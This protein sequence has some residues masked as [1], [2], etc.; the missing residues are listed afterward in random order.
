MWL[1]L[2]WAVKIM[3]IVGSNVQEAPTAKLKPSWSFAFFSPFRPHSYPLLIL[4]LCLKCADAPCQK[5]CPTN[6]D[7]K[8][9][10]TSIANKNYYG[11]AKM[12]LSDNPLG[13]TC[14]MVCPTSDLCVGGCNLYAS[15]EGPINIGGL[16]QFATEV[17]KAMNIPQIR[18]PSLP[19]LEDMPEAYQVKIALLGAGPASLSCAS[20][21]ARL[22]YSNITIFEKQEYLGGLS[23]SEIPQF[24]LPYDVV[25]FEAKLM[26]DLGVKIIFRKGLAVDGMTLHTLKEDGYKA[27][28]IGIGLPEPNRDSVFQGLKMNQGF[29]TSKDFLPLVAMASKP[30]MCGCHSPL[31]SIHGTVIVL[32][33]GDTAFDCATSALR[34]GARRVFVVFRKG[35]THIRA[36]PEEMELAK[37]EKCEFLPFLSPRKVVLKGGQ[38]VAM[39]FVRTEQDSDGNWKEDEDQIVRLKADVVISAFG[40]ILSDNKVREAMAPIKFNRWGLPEVDPETMQTSEPWVFAGGDVGGIANT[41]VESVNDGKQASWY[42]H[43]YIQSLY[44]VAVSAVPELPLFYTPVDLVDIS[45]E[46]AGLK[47]PNPFGLASAT[48]ATSSSMI[49]RAFEAGWGFAVTKT[50]SLDKDIVTNVSPR[51]V[52]GTTSGPLYGPG[53]GSF[54]NIELISEKTAAYWCKSIT[55]LKADFPNHVLIAS[56][57]CSYNRDDWTELSKMAEVAGADALELNLSCPH[58]MGER[59]MGLACGQDPELVRNI[60]RWVRQAVHIPFFAKLTPNVTDIVKIAMAAREGGA[61]GVTATNTVSGLM[62][63]KADSTPWPAVGRGLRTTYGG[64][65]GNAIRPI[66]LRAVSAIARALPGFPILATGGI[67]SAEAG[68]QFLHSGA[69]VLQVCSA[70]QNQDFTVIDDYCTGLRAL[71]YLKSIEELEDW[72][73]QSPATICHQKGKPVPRI[74]DLMGKCSVIAWST[75]LPDYA[76]HQYCSLKWPQFTSFG[77]LERTWNELLYNKEA[78]VMQNK[79][80][81]KESF[82]LMRLKMA[83]RISHSIAFP[84]FEKLPSFGPYLEQRKRIIAE[85]KIKLKAQNMA[86]ELPEK[87]HFVPKKP[88]PAIKDVIGKALQYIGT[89]GDLCNTEQVV[90]LIDEEMCINCGKCY[91]TCNDSG[92]QAIQFDPETH[93]PTVTDSCTGCTL[94]LSVCPIIDCIRM[95]SRT[96]PYEPRRGLPLAVNPAR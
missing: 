49:R 68:L 22:G 88:I 52:R 76:Y 65:S 70:I 8:S 41:T 87:K 20:F 82:G 72:N 93:L 35:F 63:L 29:Y 4:A 55:E 19:P 92:Y 38:I 27:V 75:W 21:L 44:G 5:S 61:D 50:F 9:F 51:I 85:N 34:C 53:Q 73:G 84:G 60:C 96:T 15:E 11:A 77:S 31:P 67:D 39:E 78:A 64:M 3:S 24:R 57:M 40:S 46:M 13:L 2:C 48:P 69:S 37:E 25:N 94:C 12:I 26:K 33:A 71:L 28:F 83:S 45:V 47:F 66:A 6:L 1:L 16:Q 86:A 56:I 90:A 79:R 89:Y 54:L 7:I 43:R 18:N 10:I 80:Q 30:G 36:V 14:G 59:G 42:M 95:V 62:G 23:M 58:G 81:A 17:F 91:M 74:A 32:G